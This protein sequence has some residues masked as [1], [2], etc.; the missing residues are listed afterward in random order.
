MEI[1]TKDVERLHSHLVE[2]GS[3]KLAEIASFLGGTTADARAAISKLKELHP[4]TYGDPEPK[5]EPKRRKSAP[6]APKK[7]LMLNPDG[8]T[9]EL[10]VVKATSKA[11]VFREYVAPD[12]VEILVRGEVTEIDLGEIRK[13][14]NE[15]VVEPYGMTAAMLIALGEVSR[16]G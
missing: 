9:T 16:G 14:P 15:E 10:E 3:S 1:T 13:R 7:L 5:S 11:T 4:D 2:G 12:I 8:T 6:K